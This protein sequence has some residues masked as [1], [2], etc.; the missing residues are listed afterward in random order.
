MEA[1]HGGRVLEP[2]GNVL[3][4]EVGFASQR[5]LLLA[6]YAMHVLQVP[7]Q[8]AALGEGLLALGAAERSQ[9]RVLAEV[10]A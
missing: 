8:V 1:F 5:A 2:L 6:R 4:D 10:V 3:L 9:A 7:A